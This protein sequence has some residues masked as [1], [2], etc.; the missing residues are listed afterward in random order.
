MYVQCTLI[1][2]GS[3][4][5]QPFVRPRQHW[6]ESLLPRKRAPDTIHSTL[7]NRSVGPY[8][9][10][11]PKQPMKQWRKP[12]IYQQR[13]SRLT[14]PISLACD[15]YVQYLLT[16]AN[17]TVLNQHTKGYNLGG[18]SLPHTH[19]P[20]FPTSCLPFPLVAPPG[21]HFNQVLTTKPKF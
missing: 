12:H 15:W 6:T 18:A 1:A 2:N 16:G 5:W 17:R 14:G 20:T 7:A 21:L 19:S 13:A 11:L 8:P 4:T 9:V 10:S 3:R